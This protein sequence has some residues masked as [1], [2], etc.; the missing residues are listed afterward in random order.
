MNYGGVAAIQTPF[1][2]LSLGLAEV[3]SRTLPGVREASRLRSTDADDLE[4][5]TISPPR[6]RPR[7]GA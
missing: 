5:N 7:A 6:S 2:S 3:A 1:V 4:C